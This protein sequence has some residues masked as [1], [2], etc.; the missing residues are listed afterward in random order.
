MARKPELNKATS[1][2]NDRHQ[3]Q[4]LR[5]PL[6][7]AETRAFYN[8]ISK[9]YD[10]LAEKSEEPIRRFGLRQ[11]NPQ[12]GE[13]VLEIGFGTGH[14]LE[15][16]ARAVG[17]TGAVYGI[18]LSDQMVKIATGALRR[19]ELSD[20]VALT[21]GDAVMLPFATASIDAVFTSFTLELF[22]TPEIP[23]V[24]AECKRVLRPSGRIVVVGMSKEGDTGVLVHLFEW[25]HQHFPNYLDCRPMFVRM[26][27]EEAG[28]V[29]KS[30]DKMMMWI[31]VEIVC[32]TKQSLS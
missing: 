7:K 16:I 27:V 29:I 31:P 5:V 22:D 19:Q 3:D 1:Q 8:K 26:A 21:C 17:A 28:F 4:I 12:P 23:L 24:L 10:L 2:T 6:S 9:V 32:A 15:E 25:T 30:S 20:R 11:L 13:V 18:D 14:S